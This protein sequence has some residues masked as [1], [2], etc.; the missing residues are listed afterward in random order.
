ME[1]A[2]RQKKKL[3]CLWIDWGNA[4][5]SA[6]QDV[7]GE[8]MRL[9]G[10]EPSEIALVAELYNESTLIVNNSFGRT[11]EINCNC[12]VKQGDIISPA[13][14]TI[15]MNVLLRSLSRSGAG[16][17]YS[18]GVHCNF[19][20]FADDIVLITNDPRKMQ[21]FAV[22]SKMWVN[23]SKCR[24]SAIDFNNNKPLETGHIHYGGVAFPTLD[25]KESYK[26]LGYHISVALDWKCHKQVVLNKMDSAI[27]SLRDAVYMPHQL[28]E[29]V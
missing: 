29:M 16:Y 27:N 25:A 17:M 15:L 23:H 1:D 19:L 20:A 10:F 7:L 21:T 8:A 4:F 5:N 12:G 24:M 3:Y 18:S 13:V 22:W 2:K 28:E 11:V 9:S 6:D 14:F 26:Y